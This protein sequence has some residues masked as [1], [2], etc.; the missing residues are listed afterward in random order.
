MVV[1]DLG[2]RPVQVL[3][4][5]QR[6]VCGSYGRAK[7]VAE[8]VVVGAGVSV[9]NQGVKAVLVASGFGFDLQRIIV[10][11][12]GVVNIG[13]GGERKG[14]VRQAHKTSVG[15]ASERGTRNASACRRRGY[16][17]FIAIDQ[18]VGTARTRI[19]GRQNDLAR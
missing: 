15:T 6:E 2:E 1:V 4:V 17:E 7:A 11:F 13:D 3:P 19:P 9:S 16:I 5:R 18:N 8:T 12:P 14:R 10:G